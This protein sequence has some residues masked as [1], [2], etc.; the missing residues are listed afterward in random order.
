MNLPKNSLYVPNTLIGHNSAAYQKGVGLIEVLVAVFILASGL[1]GLAALQ[2]QSLRFNHESYM[3]TVAAVFASDMA[4]RL[5]VNLDEALDTDNYKFT[6]GE[7]PSGSATAC[8]DNACTPSQLALYDYK[9]WSDELAAQLPGGK[10]SVTP[11]AKNAGGWREYTIVIQF[12]TAGEEQANGGS[13]A[14]TSTFTS[15]TRI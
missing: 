2:T 6:L 13:A 8:E 11:S 12:N 1:L 7:T 14:G 9:Q 4:D 5:R 15:R 3:K 10:G